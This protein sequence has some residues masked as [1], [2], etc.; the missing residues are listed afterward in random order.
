MSFYD[1]NDTSK[2]EFMD[3][4][5]YWMYGPVSYVFFFLYHFLK[6]KVK[7]SP[8]RS[9]KLQLRSQLIKLYVL[10]RVLTWG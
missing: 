1:V 2:F 8:N 7:F 9:A 4:V 6:V 5:S 10:A 3:F